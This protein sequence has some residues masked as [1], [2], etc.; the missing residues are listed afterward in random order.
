ME[1]HELAHQ[2][3]RNIM[4][5]LTP[6][7]NCTHTHERKT[8][9]GTHSQTCTNWEA[10]D[11][12]ARHASNDRRRSD[13][14]SLNTAAEYDCVYIDPNGMDCTA[15]RREEPRERARNTCRSVVQ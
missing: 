8:D 5:T 10:A 11:N 12:T 15:L 4:L 3:N 13:A 2:Y 14:A 6:E 9:T 7:G 1:N